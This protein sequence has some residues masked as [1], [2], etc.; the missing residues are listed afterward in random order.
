[1]HRVSAPV[2]RRAKL[3]DAVFLAWVI[4]IAG[5]SHLP[6]GSWDVALPGTEDDRLALLEDVVLGDVPSMCDWTRFLVAEVDGEA[7]AALAGY[8]PAERGLMP[9]G[10]ALAQSGAE[11]GLSDND[12]AVMLRRFAPYQRCAPPTPPGT[13]VVEW[14]ATRPEHRRQGH[15]S[16]LL[17]AILEQGRERT[18]R[19]A[20]ISFMIGNTPALNAYRARGFE[21]AEEIRHEEFERA[22]GSPGIVRM[23][24]PL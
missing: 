20:Q 5:R 24:R 1:V 16:R 13:W 12:V 22:F 19:M 15:A 2:A 10:M 17:D 8:D 9:L 23:T 7:V 21:V 4:L 11:L 6:R 14:V 3:S 18:L